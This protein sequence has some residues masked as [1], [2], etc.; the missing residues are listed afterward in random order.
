MLG[1]PDAPAPAPAPSPPR[2]GRRIFSSVPPPP[3]PTPAPSVP[4]GLVLAF[5][6]GRI[7]VRIHPAF[8][9]VALFLGASGD[10]AGIASWVAIV[11]VSV[12]LHELG[13]ATA[14]L[15]FG[16]SPEIDLHGMGGT[17]SWAAA[18]PLASGKRVVVSLAGPLAG[19][20]VGAI[21]YALA[22]AGVSPPGPGWDGAL[23]RILYV[24]VGWGILN[25]LPMLPLDGGNVLRDAL[26]IFIARARRSAGAHRVGGRRGRLRAPLAFF[27]YSQWAAI[28]AAYFLVI[29]VRA[30][31]AMRAPPAPAPFTAPR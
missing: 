16:L 10:L 7:P 23:G 19:L 4:R 9:L 20:V 15:A 24:N 29:N 31:S 18:R 25:L 17:T 5:H 12:L 2:P 6:L 1:G 8:F 22:R 27:Y 13:H 11:F 14:G 30:L 21:V 3:A 28:L 26:G